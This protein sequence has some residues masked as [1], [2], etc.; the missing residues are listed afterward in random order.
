MN[1]HILIE[2][3]RGGSLNPL[4]AYL[5]GV[6]FQCL[7]LL[8]KKPRKWTVL[9]FS[10]MLLYVIFMM[11]WSISGSAK[12]LPQETTEKILLDQGMT[13]GFVFAF[14]FIAFFL[15][16]ILR[17]IN[18]SVIISMTIGYIFLVFESRLFLQPALLITASALG[19]FFGILSFYIVI[20]KKK[21]GG[22]QK[23]LFYA[24]YFL[25][26]GFFAVSYF[27]YLGTG[28]HEL[29]SAVAAKNISAPKMVLLGMIAVQVLLNFG[30]LYY[31]FIYSL[32]SPDTRKVLVQWAEKSFGDEQFGIKKIRIFSLIQ[33]AAFFFVSF[34]LSK[35]AYE[36]FAFWI[37][38]SPLS[39][40]ILNFSIGR[41][42]SFKDLGTSTT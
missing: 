34:F 33:I 2:I 3:L 8:T 6:V 35:I 15:K 30:V 4:L 7:A 12:G 21:L 20:S 24:W 11:V 29:P 27:Y 37:L 25:V 18:E 17:A 42:S 19:I 32:F 5:S 26:N 10:A 38:L 23:T 22:L 1:F 14:L 16:D 31:S 9:I 36:L 13:Y 28:F 39:A 40:R 41:F